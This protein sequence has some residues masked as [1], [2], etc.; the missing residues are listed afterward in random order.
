M[1]SMLQETYIPRVYLFILTFA[2]MQLTVASSSSTASPTGGNDTSTTGGSGNATSSD[3]DGNY[4]NHLIVDIM[5][6]L[7][8]SLLA[9]AVAR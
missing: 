7:V 9:I 4:G 8:T 1:Y 6:I 2:A 5:T 3:D